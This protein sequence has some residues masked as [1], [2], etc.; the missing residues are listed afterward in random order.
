MTCK[1]RCLLY[2]TSYISVCSHVWVISKL[3]QLSTC[4]NWTPTRIMC[5]SHQKELNISI[6]YLFQWFM[7]LLKSHS[8]CEEVFVIVLLMNTSILLLVHATSY[9]IVWHL[10]VDSWQNTATAT[11]V[12]AL[13]LSRIDYCNSLLFGSTRDVTSHLQH[14]PNYAAKVISHIP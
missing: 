2:L 5:L 10:V 11:L 9:Y 3:G 4:F 7:V 1:Y 12:S 6:T 14:I 8:V 13:V